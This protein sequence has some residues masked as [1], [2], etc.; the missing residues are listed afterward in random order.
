MAHGL[1]CST[2]CG[3]FPDGLETMS[4][5]LAGGF[6]TTVP[7]GKPFLF[8]DSHSDRCE[9]ISHCG[10]DLHFLLISDVEHLSMCLLAICVLSLE[11]FLFRPSAH[12][13]IG[14]LIFLFF[15]IELFVCFG[16]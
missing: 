15:N 8:D 5:A 12:F 13:L 3:I 2:A 7:P 10:F 1:S 9:M 4:P 6:L 16:Y 11:K 14:L